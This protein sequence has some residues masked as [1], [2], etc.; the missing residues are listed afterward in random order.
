MTVIIALAIGQRRKPTALCVVEQ[1]Q[2]EPGGSA[3]LHHVVR[4]AMRLPPATPYPV[5]AERLGQILSK[6][7]RTTDDSPSEFVDVTGLGEPVVEVLKEK[8]PHG[9]ITPCYFTHG[10]QLGK[11]DRGV[12]VGK[13]HLVAKLQTL[14][15]A[16]RLHLPKTSEAETMARELMDYEIRVEADANERYGAFAVGT[17]YDLVTALGLAVCQKPPRR[18]AIFKG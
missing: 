2:R 3:G 10:D 7:A 18:L 15:Q 16:G 17:Q 9:R 5:V 8:A 13:G 11:E 6:L 12:R 4:H 1:E 14:L